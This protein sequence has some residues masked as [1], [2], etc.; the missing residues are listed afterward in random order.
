MIAIV[1]IALVIASAFAVAF[2]YVF[3]SWL[4]GAVWG[5]GVSVAAAEIP[6]P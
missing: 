6:D 3:V 5:C 4:L 1:I 2:H